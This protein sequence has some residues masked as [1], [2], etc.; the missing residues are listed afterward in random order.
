MVVKQG[1]VKAPELLSRTG[2]LVALAPGRA[3]GRREWV[4]SILLPSRLSPAFSLRAHSP[5]FSKTHIPVAS[6]CLSRVWP[7][8]RC[9]FGPQFMVLVD[10]KSHP[11]LGS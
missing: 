6:W 8:C 1:E 2:P 4:P 10:G 9:G 7:C 11:L 5:A 3:S